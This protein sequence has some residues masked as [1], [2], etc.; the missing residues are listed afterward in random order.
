MLTKQPEDT[1]WR[2]YCLDCG[3]INFQSCILAIFSNEKYP[4]ISKR[5]TTTILSFP[6]L[7][8]LEQT[9]LQIQGSLLWS[10]LLFFLFSIYLSFRD[11]L[12]PTAW[13]EDRAA[14][15]TIISKYQVNIFLKTQRFIFEIVRDNNFKCNSDHIMESPLPYSI[16][17]IV[18]VTSSKQDKITLRLMLSPGTGTTLPTR[19]IFSIFF[20]LYH[21][22]LHGRS[23]KKSISNSKDLKKYMKFYF[24]AFLQYNLANFCVVNS[25]SFDHSDPR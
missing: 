11:F 25:V 2:C 12:T 20:F 17:E 19:L 23:S 21:C 5:C 15:F 8:L 14:D 13:F 1:Y 7:D 9:D 3:W 6:I 22:N 4:T 18:R 10:F 16:F 24:D